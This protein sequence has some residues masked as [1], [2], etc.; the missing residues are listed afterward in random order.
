M[1]ALIEDRLAR[2]DKGSFLADRDMVDLTAFRLQVI[3]EAVRKLSAETKSAF[4]AIPWDTIVA[5]RNFIAHDYE[6]IEIERIWQV[7]AEYLGSLV[8]ACREALG[9]DGLIDL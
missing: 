9:T 5:M 8:L 3:G 6:G 1:A 7:A 4:P 2:F